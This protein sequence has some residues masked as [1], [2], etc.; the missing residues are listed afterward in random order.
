MD[1]SQM[2]RIIQ[3]VGIVRSLEIVTQENYSV[4]LLASNLIL[5]PEIS[6]GLEH[7]K[8]HLFSVIALSCG[9]LTIVYHPCVGRSS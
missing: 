4:I 8:G 5:F 6:L 2:R 1:G 9:S 3:C 7:H